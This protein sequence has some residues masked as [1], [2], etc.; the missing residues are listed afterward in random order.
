MRWEEMS[1]NKYHMTF[2]ERLEVEP[3]DILTTLD[4]QNINVDEED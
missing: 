2:R 4:I 1:Y 3:E